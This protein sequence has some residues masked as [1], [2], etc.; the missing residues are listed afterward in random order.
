MHSS[1]MATLGAP[2]AKC[3]LSATG[4]PFAYQ[5]EYVSKQRRQTITADKPNGGKC[6]LGEGLGWLDYT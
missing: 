6:L 5:P 3:S 4:L 2:Q 1:I